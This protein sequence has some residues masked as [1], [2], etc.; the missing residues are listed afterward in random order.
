MTTSVPTPS[1][2]PP[3]PIPREPPAE[4]DQPAAEAKDGAG[5]G[6]GGA[7]EGRVSEGDMD[8][9]VEGGVEK[10]ANE[11]DH[12]M[13][14]GDAPPPAPATVFRIRLKQPPSSL[15][16]KMSVPDLCRNF[17]FSPLKKL[18]ICGDDG[19]GEDVTGRLRPQFELI[20]H[21]ARRN[22]PAATGFGGDPTQG[23]FISRSPVVVALSDFEEEDHD[24]G[25]SEK[26]KQQSNLA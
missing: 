18:S 10:K 25:E 19:A 9:E 1:P 21:E 24:D 2:P 6:V 15:R 26:G 20:P 5:A 17:R 22:V 12:A 7:R 14:G 13:D 8:V 11:R 23:D 3:L 4:T 16:H